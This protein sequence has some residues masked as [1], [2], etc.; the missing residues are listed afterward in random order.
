MKG[1]VTEVAPSVYRI[2]TFHPDF[3]LQFNQFLIDDDEPFLMHTA[4]KKMFPVTLA[5]VSSVIDPSQIRWIGFS[6]FESDECGA[7]NYWLDVAPHAEPVCSLVS[8][9]VNMNDFA[10]RPAK[11]MQDGEVL[12]TGKYRFKFCSTAQL[13]HGRS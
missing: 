12:D 4:F 2:S 7:L 5:G 8:A 6:H 9:S 3:G 1:K 13:P 10:G 11:G